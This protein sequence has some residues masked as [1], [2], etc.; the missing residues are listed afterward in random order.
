MIGHIVFINKGFKIKIFVPYKCVRHPLYQGFPKTRDF[1]PKMDASIA[2]LPVIVTV[3]KLLFIKS[4]ESCFTSISFTFD[5][6][7]QIIE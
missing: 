2:T 6:F 1:L 5:I 4:K 7:Y 3:N